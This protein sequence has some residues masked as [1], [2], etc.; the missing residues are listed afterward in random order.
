[1]RIWYNRISLH[2]PEATAFLAHHTVPRVPIDRQTLQDLS[3]EIQ[4][5]VALENAQI[6]PISAQTGR[7]LDDLRVALASALPRQPYPSERL[8]SIDPVGLSAY[9]PLGPEESA[10]QET[11]T[12][13]IP[14]SEAGK[15]I[16]VA[17]AEAPE[18]A[19]TASVLDYTSSAKTGKMMVSCAQ[20]LS[21]YEPVQLH[22]RTGCARSIH[23]YPL[24]L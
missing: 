9:D 16:R 21:F 2:L 6:L 17:V 15:A 3:K 7:G 8:S 13:G 4:E 18:G 19:A 1:M 12:S 22:V 10:A 5:F 11:G 24:L 20:V 23:R 14:D